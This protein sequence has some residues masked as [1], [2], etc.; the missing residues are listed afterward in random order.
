MTIQKQRQ[1]ENVKSTACETTHCVLLW[2][3]NKQ[4]YVVEFTHYYKKGH[5]ISIW[6]ISALNSITTQHKL[7]TSAGFKIRLHSWPLLF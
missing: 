3:P 6:T 5:N 2:Q 7:D 4:A 1:T